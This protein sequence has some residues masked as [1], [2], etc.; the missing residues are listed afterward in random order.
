MLAQVV[1]PMRIAAVPSRVAQGN[2]DEHDLY[3]ETEARW[4]LVETAWELSLSRHLVEV[5]ADTNGKALFVKSGNKRVDI[6]SSRAAL[7]GYQKGKCFYCYE[8]IGITT[9]SK[10][11]ADVDH[12]LPHTLMVNNI[13]TNLD[14]VWNLVLA[15]QSCNRGEGGK[16]AMVPHIEFL[17]RL[18]KRNEYLIAS[19]HPLRETLIGQTGRNGQERGKYLQ[20]CYTR[21]S[22]YLIHTWKPAP[23]GT[24][25]F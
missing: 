4:R 11:L 16:F 10:N 18:H 6:T 1:T 3:D 17:R 2:V 9:N 22:E 20:D 25:R 23:K 13:T 5:S 8:A 12:F 24:G 14:G 15:C 19:H 21:A 7:N